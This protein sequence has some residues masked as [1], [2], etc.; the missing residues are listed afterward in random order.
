MHIHRD[1][2]GFLFNEDSSGGPSLGL[3]SACLQ[4]CVD[5]VLARDLGGVFGR[6]PEFKE[7]DL[8]CLSQLQHLSSVALWDINLRD[9]SALDDLKK[10]VYFRISGKR[11]ALDLARLKVIQSLVIEHHRKDVGLRELHNLRML[12]LWHYKAPSSDSFEL[13]LPPNLEEFGLNWS[14]V[15]SLDGFGHCPN[16]KK[17]EIARCRNL[18]SLGKLSQTFPKLEHLVV[19]AC[20]RLI[21]DEARKALSGHK[22]IRHAFAGKELIV[23]SRVQ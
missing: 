21:A 16:V 15:E 3:E 10:L 19:G 7:L 5:E 18:K 6:H 22:N 9:L 20:G 4:K 11:P 8:S 2:K 1:E 12:H 23:S 17:L 13:S 14:N